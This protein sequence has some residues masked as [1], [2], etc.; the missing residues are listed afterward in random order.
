MWAADFD[1][2]FELNERLVAGWILS[3]PGYPF[4]ATDH[5]QMKGEEAIGQFIVSQ[6]FLEA[7]YTIKK[8]EMT[9][10]PDSHT[11]R[12]NVQFSVVW[13]KM[14]YE[15]E[16]GAKIIGNMMDMYYAKKVNKEG[17]T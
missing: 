16:L 1:T 13:E 3:A 9:W 11:F 7:E 12:I 17:Q 4:T 15:E 5:I 14:R 10:L 8:F 2:D 6:G